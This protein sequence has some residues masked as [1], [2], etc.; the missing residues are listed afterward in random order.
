MNH[1]L[2]NNAEAFFLVTSLIHE[3]KSKTFVNKEYL[4][5]SHPPS[6]FDDPDDTTPRKTH[7]P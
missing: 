7:N 3:V 2:C 6:A 1:L 5:T 4:P